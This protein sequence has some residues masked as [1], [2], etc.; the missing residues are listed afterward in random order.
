MDIRLQ[1]SF[2]LWISMWISDLCGY[3]FGYPWRSMDIRAST[4]YGFSIQGRQAFKFETRRGRFL[5]YEGAGT[6]IV[7]EKQRV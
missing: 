6:E 7:I 1:L 3:P 4:C 5:V 2:L